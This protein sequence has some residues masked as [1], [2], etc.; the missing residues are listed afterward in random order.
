[1]RDYDLH[2]FLDLPSIP[3]LPFGGV[4]AG[5]QNCGSNSFVRQNALESGGDVMLLRVDNEYLTTASFGQFFSDL[6][7]EFSFLGIQLRFGKIAC[8]GNH[9]PDVALEFRIKLRPVQGSQ[10][11]R[12]IWI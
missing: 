6:F 11:I 3:G 7:D 12:M 10:A 1:M 4:Y 9:K 5:A 2:S 8:L